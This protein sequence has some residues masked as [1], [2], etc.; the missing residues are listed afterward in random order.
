MAIMFTLNG[1]NTLDESLGLQ[2]GTAD[3]PQEDNDDNDVPLSKLQSD[4]PVFYNRLF[5]VS[6]LNLDDT[7]PTDVGVAESADD[8]IEISATG[9][10]T[11]LAF[12]DSNGDPLGD[13]PLSPVD[14]GLDTLEADTN[15]DHN[16]YLFTDNENDNIVLGKTSDGTT[17][18]SAYIEE[19]TNN[20]GEIIGAKIW[21][22]ALVPLLHS[23][24]ANPDDPESILA[25]RLFVTASE[26]L[27]FDLSTLA[28]QQNDWN[29]MG[30]A[31]NQ[32]LLLPDDPTETI[33]T[34]QGGGSTT[35][36]NSNQLINGIIFDNMGA[37]TD[38]GEAVIFTF[39]KDEP[40]LIDD[41]GAD[42]DYDDTST[43]NV[44]P[45]NLQTS[46]GAEWSISQTQ[47]GSPFAVATM[48]ALFEDPEDWNDSPP[49]GTSAFVNELG[50]DDIVQITS[51]TVTS[52]A[53]IEL[54]TAE[55]DTV[56]GGMQS[57]SVP[58]TIGK[59]GN[60]QTF[61]LTVTFN[62]DGT[63]TVSGLRA[64]DTIA[65][66]AADDHNRVMIANSGVE[67]NTLAFDIG[68][69]VLKEAQPAPD[70]KL[71]FTVERVD[72]DEDSAEAS[73]SIGID[74]TGI[75][76]DDHVDGVDPPDLIA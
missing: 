56:A 27:V 10:I 61:N 66:L 52:V 19:V 2:V 22:V 73:F 17:V 53:G 30:D 69:F 47:G 26:E 11:G 71:D 42:Q 70:E 15:G 75:N 28:S 40:D 76:D 68:G 29:A 25:D 41:I 54:I 72:E 43:I 48:T 32:I 14:S 18:W 24:D 6:E 7:F 21:M 8:F 57:Y 45:L 59:G 67:A 39:F 74:G 12:T 46:N 3:L 51:V 37:V 1:T 55:Y 31:S 38:D 58:R 65:Y 44:D 63:A 9:T 16:I 50:D 62:L 60:Q 4:V 5:G 36:G 33:N 35:I 64:D 34:S 13:D 49:A 23:D 20:E